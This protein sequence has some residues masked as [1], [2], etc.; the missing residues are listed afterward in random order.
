MISSLSW[1]YFCCIW[2]SSSYCT[3]HFCSKSSHY[4]W[5]I[6]LLLWFYATA[7]PSVAIPAPIMQLYLIE[8]LFFI[9][10]LQLIFINLLS[11]LIFTPFYNSSRFLIPEISYKFQYSFSICLCWIRIDISMS[12]NK[13]QITKLFDFIVDW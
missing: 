13:F 4:F 5:V 6:V 12:L 2:M 7:I 8:F 10:T 9:D 1:Q 11:L 3:L